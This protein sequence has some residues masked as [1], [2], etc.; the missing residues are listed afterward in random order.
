M[1]LEP[2]EAHIAGVVGTAGLDWDLEEGIGLLDWQLTVQGGWL[3]LVF[4]V[5]AQADSVAVSLRLHSP[6]WIPYYS[7]SKS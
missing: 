7:V 3:E 5:L 6:H 2:L 4:L 1:R